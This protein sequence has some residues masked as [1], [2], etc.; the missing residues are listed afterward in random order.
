MKVR[1]LYMA[2]KIEEIDDKYSELT[3]VLT[4][5]WD[6]KVDALDAKLSEELTREI[7]TNHKLTRIEKVAEI[8]SRY[9]FEDTLYE[10]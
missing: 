10:W 5:R 1:I 8:E 4:D 2:E 7:P 3:D 6:E 9:P